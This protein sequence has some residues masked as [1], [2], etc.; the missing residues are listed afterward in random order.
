[1]LKITVQ[2]DATIWRL[3][4]S[5]RLVGPW[6]AETAKVW[7]SVPQSGKEVEVNLNEV[8]RID[9]AGRRLLAAMHRAGARLLTGGVANSALIAEITR[10]CGSKEIA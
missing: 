4:L 10:P 1:M 6:V 5:G 9:S 8:T 3:N 7:R 2:E